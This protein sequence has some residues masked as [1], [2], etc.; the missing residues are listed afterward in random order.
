M[1]RARAVDAE[2][3]WQG[4]AVWDVRSVEDAGDWHPP[5]ETGLYLFDTLSARLH[6]RQAARA[7][8]GALKALDCPVHVGGSGTPEGQIIEATGV[9]GLQELSEA[10]GRT[11]GNGVK[12]QSALFACEARNRPQVFAQ[13]LHVIPHGDGT[14]AVG[15][16]SEREFEAPDSVDDQLEDVIAKARAICPALRDAKVIERWAGV[17]PRARSRAPMLGRHPLRS[18]HFI[19]N[20]GFKIGFGMAPKVAE[21]MADLVLSGRDS[22]PEGFRPEASL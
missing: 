22:I 6:P 3:N 13:S 15:S 17:R 12:G 16:T 2:E 21:V 14:V 11:V 1:A 7:I 20:G 5:S 18:E 10:F 8:S 19:A 9:A 4:L